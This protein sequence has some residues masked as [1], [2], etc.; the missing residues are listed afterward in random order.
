V[1]LLERYFEFVICDPLIADPTSARHRV[2]A[3]V[4][5]LII[6]ETGPDGAFWGNVAALVIVAALTVWAYSTLARA[7]RRARA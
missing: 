5:L 3:M 7:T 6:W 2:P 1:R 4:D